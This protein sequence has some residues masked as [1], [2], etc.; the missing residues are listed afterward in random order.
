MTITSVRRNCASTLA[1][2]PV[3]QDP[4]AKILLDASLSLTPIALDPRGIRRIA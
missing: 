2:A 3:P 1:K 4:S